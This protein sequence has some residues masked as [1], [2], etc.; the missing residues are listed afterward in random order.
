[1]GAVAG[2]T[3]MTDKVEGRADT[4]KALVQE[5]YG[6]A[7]ALHVRDIPRPELMEGHV[8]ASTSPTCVGSVPN[9][10][11]SDEG[12]APPGKARSSPHI[13]GARGASR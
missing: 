12:A 1:M 3:E 9:P 5:G 13:P 10:S 7:D 11:S 2:A 4:M 8:L 6:S